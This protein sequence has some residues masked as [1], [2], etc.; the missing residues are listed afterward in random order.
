[1]NIKD[2]IYDKDENIIKDTKSDDAYDLNKEY[3]I[4]DNIYTFSVYKKKSGIYSIYARK[5]I[6]KGNEKIRKVHIIKKSNEI[7]K[8]NLVLINNYIN[9]LKNGK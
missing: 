6:K 9:N 8:D 3:E 1:M 4:E 5:K 7:S 2:Y